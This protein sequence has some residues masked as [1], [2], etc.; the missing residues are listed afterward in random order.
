MQNVKLTINIPEDLHRMI[1]AHSVLSGSTMKDYLLDL[2]TN[3]MRKT[4][5]KHPNKETVAA[6]LEAKNGKTNLYKDIND[7]FNKMDKIGRNAKN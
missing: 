3:S 4:K 5:A 2:V 7:L 6:L 1:K